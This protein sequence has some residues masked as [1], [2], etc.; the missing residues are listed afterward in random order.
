MKGIRLCTAM[1]FSA[2]LTWAHAPGASAQTFSRVLEGPPATDVADAPGAS[3]I[4]YD[5]DGDPDLFVSNRSTINFLYRNDGGSFSRA[6]APP[7]TSSSSIGSCWADYDNDGDLDVALAG[8][9]SKLIRNDGNGIFTDVTTA[10]LPATQSVRAW[11]CSWAD[12][13]A[14]G[15]ADLFFAHP[16]GFVGSPSQNNFLFRGTGEG[17]FERVTTG[18]IVTGL[19]PY[20]VGTWSD[21]DADGDFDLF[22]GS[23]PADGSQAPDYLYKNLLTESGEATFERINGLP[24]AKNADG[25]V[26]NWIDYDN[27]GDLD[28]FRTNYSGGVAGGLRDD[29]FRNDDGTFVPVTTGLLVTLSGQSLAN[30][31]G[32]YDNDGFIDV[33]VVEDGFPT[34]AANRLFRNDGNGGFERLLVSPLTSDVSRSWGGVSADYDDDG[35]LDLFVPTLF[36]QTTM[37]ANFLYKNELDNGNHWLKVTLTG[38]QSNRSGI[39]AV[40]RVTAMTD[41]TVVT[42]RRDVSSQNTFNG[43]NDYTVHFGLGNAAT[44]VSLTVN[45]P[46]G[47]FD[48]LTDVPVDQTVAIVE[49]MTP[50]YVEDSGGAAEFVERLELW[51]NPSRGRF[52]ARFHSDGSGVASV[53][54]VDALGRVL[55]RST[56][57]VPARS[58]VDLPI[59]DSPLTAG[60]YGIR[61]ELNGRVYTTG[62]VVRR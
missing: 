19:A 25:Q 60:W 62:V 28:A 34:G 3:W 33:F 22:V 12:Y 46:S 50:A 55:S 5:G 40:V 57:A 21:Y 43:T 47:V 16:A 45:W 2:A 42:Q 24:L 35:D 1:L 23:G 31:W 49:G 44:V 39:G 32:D 10:L 17:E 6:A 48:E 27:D 41:T 51:P 9:P 30:V 58:V 15:N 4:D 53:S 8:T 14:D 61:V 54:I 59:A 56:V 36:G 38:R 7:I 26:W 29:F 20:T 11:S 52:T 18:P 37:P 13:D